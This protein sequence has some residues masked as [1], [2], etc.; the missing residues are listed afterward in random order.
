MRLRR[1]LLC[2]HFAQ[3]SVISVTSS[4]RAVPNKTPSMQI[5]F[6]E[7]H[8]FYVSTHAELGS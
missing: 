6:C 7:L 3:T 2:S 8:K 4:G 1:Q 5:I